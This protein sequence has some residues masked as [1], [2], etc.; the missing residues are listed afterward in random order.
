[1]DQKGVGQ[2]EIQQS[3]KGHDANSSKK[4]KIQPGESQIEKERKRERPGKSDEDRCLGDP[5]SSVNKKMRTLEKVNENKE[6]ESDGVEND[7]S[8]LYRHVSEKI[9]EATQVLDAATKVHYPLHILNFHCFLK[10]FAYLSIFPLQK[11]ISYY[12][13]QVIPFI[14][15]KRHISMNEFDSKRFLNNLVTCN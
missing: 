10:P 4:E 13:F 2:S 7:E 15:R 9:Q 12:F 11:K 8:N 1:M 6:E 3:M 14:K 5:E